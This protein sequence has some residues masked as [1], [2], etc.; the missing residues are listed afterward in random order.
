MV[1]RTDRV[2]A[3]AVRIVSWLETLRPARLF[4]IYDLLFDY[5]QSQSTRS[6]P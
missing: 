3:A 2:P 5:L 1:S 6:R 4:D